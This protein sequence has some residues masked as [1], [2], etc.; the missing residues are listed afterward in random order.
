MEEEAP[1]FVA[2]LRDLSAEYG[3]GASQCPRDTPRDSRCRGREGGQRSG[4]K[5]AKAF[6]F[7]RR[8]ADLLEHGLRQIDS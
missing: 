6:L 5:S 1:A 2:L 7:T 4:R 3:P 8:S